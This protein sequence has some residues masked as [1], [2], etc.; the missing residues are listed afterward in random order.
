MAEAGRTDGPAAPSRASP[1]AQ[2]SNHA[3]V[4]EP[5]KVPNL[6]DYQTVFTASK[7][8]MEGTCPS[9]SLLQPLTRSRRCLVSLDSL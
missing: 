6:A 9:G 4:Q 3:P 8:G 2:R 7:A 1:G 5:R